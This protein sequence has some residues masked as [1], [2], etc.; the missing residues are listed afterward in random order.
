MASERLSEGMSLLSAISNAIVGAQKRY[1]GK[2]P[3]AAKSYMLDDML[4]VVMQGGLT[5]AE[6]TMLEF[7]REDL[8]RQFRQTF[9]NDM[10]ARMTD[11]VEELTGRR[12]ITYQS[13]ILFG[14]ARV[15]EMFVLDDDGPRAAREAT[16]GGQLTDASA[17]T[18]DD[19]EAL[20]APSQGGQ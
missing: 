12:V 4:F 7:G 13:Q 8:V 5:V 20:D 17:G 18:A 2:G 3:V 9:E 10:T 15:V 1:F 16:A 19:P 14:P 11:I 6:E